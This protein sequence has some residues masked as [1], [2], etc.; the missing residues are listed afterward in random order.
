M[1]RSLIGF[2]IFAVIAIFMLKLLFGLFGLV[3]GLVGSVLWFALVGFV[4]YQILKLVA[5]GTA[6]RLRQTITGKTV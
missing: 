4:I 2:A 1:I 5:P 6:A 3:L